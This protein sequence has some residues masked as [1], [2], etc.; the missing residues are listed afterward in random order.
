MQFQ[1]L[2][3]SLKSSLV[4]VM[5]SIMV[6]ALSCCQ[7]KRE[8]LREHGSGLMMISY[9]LFSS[10]SFRSVNMICLKELRVL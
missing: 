9:S 7:L 5:K 3:R 10:S 2:F 6:T 1:V 4:L 8:S